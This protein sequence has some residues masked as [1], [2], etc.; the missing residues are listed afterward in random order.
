MTI[1]FARN[2][3]FVQRV[4]RAVQMTASADYANFEIMESTRR[5]VAEG[6]AFCVF[7]DARC[8]N[9]LNIFFSFSGLVVF[10]EG[11][12]PRASS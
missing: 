12:V 4:S 6:Q 8:A 2:R 5:P 9:M 11:D 1:G 7:R 10:N 3:P